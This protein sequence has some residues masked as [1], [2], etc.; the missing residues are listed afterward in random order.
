MR[1][2]D[3]LPNHRILSYWWTEK[4]Q[5]ISDQCGGVR[6]YST[7]SQAM[8][9][10]RDAKFL[11]QQDP[12]SYVMLSKIFVIQMYV[13]PVDVIY[14]IYV[15]SHSRFKKYPWHGLEVPI[16]CRS[17]LGV[18][19][20]HRDVWVSARFS[21]LLKFDEVVSVEA[22]KQ[23]LC[24]SLQERELLFIVLLSSELKL[25][26]TAFKETTRSKLNNHKLC[27]S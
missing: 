26:N 14:S 19:R 13:F 2:R 23:N 7:E 9:C 27:G 22:K 15:D 1:K 16:S 17:V 12:S 10:Q 21:L 5:E 24:L 20:W 4:A 8:M 11:S 18:T 25:N 3:Y 6:I